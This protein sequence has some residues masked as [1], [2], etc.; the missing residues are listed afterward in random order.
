[1]KKWIYGVVFGA[2]IFVG[3]WVSALTV[4]AEEVTGSE[5][6]FTHSHNGGCYEDVQVSCDSKHTSTGKVTQSVHYCATCG[7]DTYQHT[8][9]N[10]WKC[11][12]QGVTW[13]KD[14]Y[15][16]CN[17][18]GTYSAQWTQDRPGG[19]VY[20][21]RQLTCGMKEG[22]ATAKLKIYA[23]GNWTNGSVMLYA[24][25][26]VLKQDLSSDG[27]TLDWENGTLCTAE[28]G[29]YTVTG[30]NSRGNTISSTIQISC[31]DKI[32]PVINEKNGNT[33]TMTEN[34]IEVS[35]SASDGESG[36]ADAPYSLDGGVTWGCAATFKVEEGKPVSFVVRDKAGNVAACTISR[37]QFP[38][39]PK[40][41]APV[42]PPVAPPTNAAPPVAPP[43]D[44]TTLPD[45]KSADAE[46]EV[47]SGNKEEVPKEKQ[48]ENPKK[49]QVPQGVEEKKVKEEEKEKNTDAEAPAV[50]KSILTKEEREQ[51]YGISVM[52]QKRA[53]DA[54]FTNRKE[55]SVQKEMKEEDSITD[56]PPVE[57]GLQ[58]EEAAPAEKE[59]RQGMAVWLQQN[60]ITC[61]GVLLCIF[62]AGSL[63]YLLW[64]HTAILYCYD[65][66]E[67]YRKIGIFQIK[68]GKKELELYLPDYILQSTKAFRYRLMLRNRL[69]KRCQNRELVVYNEDNKL[70]QQ[71]EECVDFVL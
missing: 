7:G 38:Y 16:A 36:L 9:I 17:V 61:I 49:I 37:N 4:R 63:V 8:L 47:E 26:E 43:T 13:Q 23:D 3:F 25:T 27:I 19:H 64:M 12:I 42:A 58:K 15:T 1:M 14:C 44:V 18:C 22:E 46:K 51:A 31:I 29:S 67:E 71:V 50:S 70:R 33:D 62:A 24:K 48:E 59:D 6:V 39:P 20:K 45:T 41:Q 53:R 52:L 57:A 40:A 11:P 32:A 56:T 35:V 2:V 30:K 5:G 34:G 65:G 68:R 60:G 21:E 54:F 10:E 55:K 69:V 28:N 66:G